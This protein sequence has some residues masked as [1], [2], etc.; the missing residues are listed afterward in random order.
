[1]AKRLL[2]NI[3]KRGAWLELGALALILLTTLGV[4]K[5]FTASEHIY[6]G[7][8]SKG[9]FYDYKVCPEEVKGINKENLI[10]FGNLKE[11]DSVFER[12]EGCV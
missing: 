2:P 12:A 8:K 10:I 11:A 4:A 5:V 9:V 1:M 7:D 3:N 6:A